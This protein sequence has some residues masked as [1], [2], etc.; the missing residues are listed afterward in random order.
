MA[1]SIRR[2]LEMP[3]NER[4]E[5]M[6]LMRLH[7]SAHDIYHWAESCLHDVDIEVGRLAS[8]PG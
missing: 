1:D 3:E 6:R 8:V 7:L 5:R 2:A 4:R